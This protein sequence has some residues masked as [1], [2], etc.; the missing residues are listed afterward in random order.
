ML[1]R[2]IV[3][4]SVCSCVLLSGC[5]TDVKEALGF[6][7][8]APDEFRVVS[9]PPLSVPDTF[10]L[11]K[12]ST[13]KHSHLDSINPRMEAKNTLFSFSSQGT[14]TFSKGENLFLQNAGEHIPDIRSVLN[15]EF[16]TS[17]THRNIQRFFGISNPED[18]SLETVVDAAAERKRLLDNKKMGKPPNHGDV[19]I[20]QKE[21][22][23]SI[24]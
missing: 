4:L 5:S 2:N 1:V 13:Q 10:A 23:I 22:F 19:P 24:F 7:K 17:S 15:Q 14:A 9:H 3:V 20:L 11:P 16:G 21:S 6:V 18:A 12:P 8:E